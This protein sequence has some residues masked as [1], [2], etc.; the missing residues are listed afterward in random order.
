METLNNDIHNELRAKGLVAEFDSDIQLC[1]QY[2]DNFTDCLGSIDYYQNAASAAQA[3]PQGVINQMSNI[4]HSL[5]KAPPVE[6]PDF[7]SKENEC[8]KKYIHQFEQIVTKFNYSEVDKFILLK[9]HV[10]GKAAYLIESLDV[11][12]QNY[13]E[14]VKIITD[15][16][17]SEKKQIDSVIKQ[18]SKLNMKNFKEPFQFYGEMMR[19]LQA[20]NELKIST[21]Q[22]YKFFIW[23]ALSDDFKRSF[24]MET[25]KKRPTLDELKANFSK[26]SDWCDDLQSMNKCDN[27]KSSNSSENKKHSSKVESRD[28]DHF[29]KSKSSTIMAAGV[30][31]SEKG[32]PN[33]KNACSLCTKDNG[34]AANHFLKNCKRYLNPEDKV[35]KL[36]L[37]Q[38]CIGC[39][40]L[41]HQQSECQIIDENKKCSC[42]IGAKHFFMLCTNK[43]KLSNP[44]DAKSKNGNKKNKN[45]SQVATNVAQVS[46]NDGNN[47]ESEGTDSTTANLATFSTF[48]LAGGVE[49]HSLLPTLTC[50]I[51][52]EMIRSLKDTGCQ[53]NFILKSVAEKLNLPVIEDNVSLNIKG[54]NCDQT[55][56]TK[57]VKVEVE[58]GGERFELQALCIPSFNVN[59][60][61][62][63]LGEIVKGFQSKG[64]ILA[65]KFLNEKSQ[66]IDNISLLLGTKDAHI[67]KSTD[68]LFG[69][70]NNSSYS[71]TKG[72]IM[73]LGNSDLLWENLP[74]LPK[75]KNKNIA[76][77]SENVACSIK[78]KED[79]RFPL[80]KCDKENSPDDTKIELNSHVVVMDSEGK[81]NNSELLKAANEILDRD[82]DKLLAVEH[83]NQDENETEVNKQLV[84]YALDNL[85][86]TD[87]NRIKIP[88]LWNSKTQH[89][90]GKNYNLSKAVLNSNLPK[91]S[92][93]ES[94]LKL[95]DETFREQIKAGIIEKIPDL[96]TFMEENPYFSFLPHM[97]VFKMKRETTK[98]RVVF[99]SN[100]CE[101]DPNK[102]ATFSHNQTIEPGPC[103]Y[104]KLS[105]S[106]LQLR[107]DE[108][109]LIY[110][111]KKAFNQIQLNEEDANRLLF[112][113]Y[114]DPLKG[115]FTIEAYRNV[116][117]S[118]GLRC[119]PTILCLCLY[120][121]LI[122]DTEE[123]DKKVKQLKRHMFNLLYVDNGAV[124]CN[125][126]DELLWAYSKLGEIFGKYKFEIQQLVTNSP[127]LQE[128]LKP[129]ETVEKSDENEVKLLGCV[130]NKND[131]TLAP[132]KIQLN[133]KACTKR[134]ILS[135]IAAQFDLNN[136]HC[137][138]MNR[139]RLFLHSL[140]CNKNLKWDDTL[141]DDLLKQWKNI[142]SQVNDCPPLSMPR[143]IGKRE[144]SYDLIACTD[145]SGQ[146]FGVVIYMLNK[147]TGKMHLVQSKNRIINSSQQKRTIPNLEL[148]AIELGVEC[149][150]SLYR[151]LTNDN[152]MEKI[153]IENLKIFSD[154][155]V[156]LSWV[157]DDNL[158]L[159]KMQKR[160]VFTRNRLS[161]IKKL[162][163]VHPVQFSFL[164]GS[165]NPADCVTRCVSYKILKGTNYLNG[166]SSNDILKSET[167]TFCLTVPGKWDQS[168]CENAILANSALTSENEYCSQTSELA[169]N[170]VILSVAVT[171]KNSGDPLELGKWS[172]YKRARK[173]SL[174]LKFLFRK[175]KELYEKNPVKFSRYEDYNGEE[176]NFLREAYQILIREEQ[177]KCF[178]EIFHYFSNKFCPKNKVPT[179][180]NQLNLMLDDNGLLR[181]QSKMQR[182][183]NQSENLSFPI[184]LPKNSE[185]T[186]EIIEYLHV[187]N[188][189]INCYTI[190]AELRKQF[191]IPCIYS[192]VKKVIN[193]CVVCRKSNARNIKLTQNSY[194]LWRTA[195]I[196]IPFAYS[197][198]DFLGH[199]Y[200]NKA[201]TK[202][203]V[204]L[205]IISCMYTRAINLVL[206]EDMTVNE[207]LRAYQMHCFSHGIGQYIISDMGSQI[208]AGTKIMTTF[209]NDAET[210]KNFEELGI[211]SIK[212]DQYPKGNSSLG[213]MVESG[214]KL[215]KTLIRSSIG[216]NVLK[217][218]DFEFLVAQT[219][220]LVNRRPIAFKEALRDK[221][222]D[223]IPEVITPEKLLRGYDLPT[224]NLIPNLQ[225]APV[226][227]PDWTNDPNAAICNEFDKLRA[228]RQKLIETYEN[229][230]F[231]NLVHQAV[232][233]KNRY[234]K[235]SSHQLDLGDVVMLR[236]PLCKIF[237]SPLAIVRK[238]VK[239]NIGEV[240][241]IEVKKGSTGEI[242]RRHV[243]SVAFLFRPDL[244]RDNKE[245]SNGETSQATQNKNSTDSKVD[246]RPSRKAAL[247]FQKNLRNMIQ[248]GSLVCSH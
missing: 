30:Q 186:I 190:L 94:F 36:L 41:D 151:E 242:C 103:M 174:V 237:N 199:Y 173:L 3:P 247:K 43:N 188:N 12:D 181:V 132:R 10:K 100:L 87:E 231:A 117:L 67:L 189:H 98:C 243:T 34:S 163:N 110:D 137:P 139:S 213:S 241:E 79:R 62:K 27:H 99:L 104:S 7:H 211:K 29:S 8:F 232:N 28:T 68:V 205:L 52:N 207:F 45:K 25:K 134:Q 166:P 9:Q 118:F 222:A 197:F 184:L 37:Y 26:A 126:N 217:L 108:K 143:M 234:E 128:K 175:K 33:A 72:G 146:I 1:C 22:I 203:K 88:L 171:D 113:W 155:L 125:S 142:V 123:D 6:L 223:E 57:L 194:R 80:K 2:G 39:G 14:A 122:L 135:T 240:T 220:N 153:K 144:G 82:C 61:P 60:R 107:F 193:K 227:D 182:Y 40:K 248:D 102:I 95:M 238:I 76:K 53:G 165:K 201:G 106:L 16:L 204:W 31:Y 51:G 65:D 112:L 180:V 156:A 172:L 164:S 192:M 127:V 59:I 148:Q 131:D 176:P 109:V 233:R 21:E 75:L 17:A 235:V 38:G 50:T 81:L 130:W 221:A 115:D 178:H 64:Y 4:N 105:T 120:F 145:A 157:A 119:S 97:G 24:Q 162:C 46:A 42:N 114:K 73:L 246:K 200:V 196:K 228:V 187:K 195:P 177:K 124:T 48:A 216:K 66:K 219:I 32:K 101:K 225:P 170:E 116:R 236:D 218:R 47:E 185:V 136:I 167:E 89:L 93:N 90:L 55:Y 202:V 198:L 11:N 209:L 69:R 54:F 152:C 161:S 74:Y 147:E 224:G 169:L 78:I 86:V 230:F 138:I 13:K 229:E 129:D 77:K 121:I 226:A 91:L 84:Q 18:F 20:S 85:T 208:V 70:K 56:N 183:V 133:A 179:L 168:S 159:E 140:Q 35:N 23:N 149:L 111:L 160:S 92:K 44:K 158:T 58:F 15:S 154:S 215:V 96:S 71:I 212:F 19:L 83:C 245:N 244:K 206:C 5:L 210:A 141:P 63:Q 214:V 49:S 191:Y 150:I 239:N